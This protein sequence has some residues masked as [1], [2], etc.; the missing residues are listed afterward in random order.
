MSLETDLLLDRRRLKRHLAVWRTLAV[1]AVLLAVLVAVRGQQ[2]G[3]ARSHVARL[4]VSGIIPADRKRDEAVVK[5]LDNDSVKALI[6]SIDS[7]GGSVAGG[8][9]APQALAPRAAPKPP[10]G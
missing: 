3:F 8:G 6:V 1:L 7:P 9:G 10:G 4:T 5:L 2:A